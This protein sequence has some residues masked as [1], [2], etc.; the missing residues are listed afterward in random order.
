M[1]LCRAA[2]QCPSLDR[3]N[4]VGPPLQWP[5][6]WTPQG[7]TGSW[8]SDSALTQ[9]A[10]QLK[11]HGWH[12]AGVHPGTAACTVLRSSIY[13]E[14]SLFST[15]CPTPSGPSGVPCSRLRNKQNHHSLGAAPEC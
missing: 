1:G 9:V 8:G 2:R 6:L 14:S 10:Q 12:L 15:P 5:H 13:Q 3:K 7:S 4:G 11:V